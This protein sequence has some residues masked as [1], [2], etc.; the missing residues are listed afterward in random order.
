M[1]GALPVGPARSETTWIGGHRAL[2][3]R[4]DDR[5]RRR[6][7]GRVCRR[8]WGRDRGRRLGRR[9][10][11]GRTRNV[12]G[13][14]RRSCVGPRCGRPGW[15]NKGRGITLDFNSFEIRRSFCSSPAAR[16]CPPRFPHGDGYVSQSIGAFPS[17]YFPNPRSF[18]FWL[19]LLIPF[20]GRGSF[21]RRH[22]PFGT[23]NWGSA[24]TR[25]RRRARAGTRR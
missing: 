22:Y 15:R 19:I 21:K 18:P 17:A 6:G 10:R 5:D 20:N 9:R 2:H 1:T 25:R 14:G 23:R 13:P 11:L 3:W 16:F 12:E 8:R 4:R 7:T 24:G